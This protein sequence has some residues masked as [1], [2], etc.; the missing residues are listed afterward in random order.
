[1]EQLELPFKDR[2]EVFVEELLRKQKVMGGPV[3]DKKF[4]VDLFKR[5]GVDGW[6]VQDSRSSFY[7]GYIQRERGY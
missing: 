7:Y 5:V 1:M 6:Y 4:W 2:V 3:L